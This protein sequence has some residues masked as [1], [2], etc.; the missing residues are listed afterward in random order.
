MAG[1]KQGVEVRLR[2]VYHG[3]QDYSAVR[4]KGYIPLGGIHI[5]DPNRYLSFV[6]VKV[7]DYFERLAVHE[8]NLPEF[9]QDKRMDEV[10]Q[11]ILD[12]VGIQPDAVDLAESAE[13]FETVFDT[14]VAKTRAL[15]EL[16]KV[17]NSELGYAY[18]KFDNRGAVLTGEARYTRGTKGLAEVLIP[19]D[20]VEMLYEDG[21]E[22][23]TETGE[24]MVYGDLFEG[25]GARFENSM[26]RLER[27]HA[28]N[29]VN[30]L[31]VV[32]YP[33]EVDSEAVVLWEL[34]TPI[35]VNAGETV[36]LTVR[37][38]DPEQKAQSVSAIEIE[39]PDYLMNGAE[40]GSGAD[41]SAALDVV[42]SE[43][44]NGVI[45]EMENTG[46][47]LGYVTKLVVSGVGVYVYQPIEVVKELEAG[48]EA[49]GRVEKSLNMY[50]QNNP[51]V[52]YD[53]ANYLLGLYSE[54][55]TV[56]EGVSF[57]ANK[58]ELLACSFMG[59]NVGDR[60]QVI[61]SKAGVDS[62]YFIHSVQYSVAPGGIVFY[63][64]GVCDA[65]L[66]TSDTFW[67]IGVEGSGNI[68]ETTV[69]GF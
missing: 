42:F 5:D 30:V 24:V 54:K 66:T 25:V 40:D 69:L 60:V 55:R 47:T 36:F 63:S 21:V 59:L 3:K 34:N 20:S 26:M 52:A 9:A 61:S 23:L 50:Y 12:N 19:I 65:A 27:V 37:F 57:S 39:E 53:F 51:L 46:G 68:G 14:V 64:F 49:D 1:F 6:S 44:V 28:E 16:A 58:N 67:L 15:T 32:A 48:I 43:G 11:L 18:L 4:F 17:V 29:Y 38:R 13:E 62:E 56:I 45:V 35:A 8:M 10:I 22:M 7:V 31:R 2:F 33:R 41:L